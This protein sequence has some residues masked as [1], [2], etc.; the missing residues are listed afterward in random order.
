[1]NTPLDSFESEAS[2]LGR[3]KVDL[4]YS[5]FA[6]DRAREAAKSC[7]NRDAE[8]LAV[9]V[10]REAEDE[11]ARIDAR[12]AE[13]APLI[14]EIRHPESPLSTHQFSKGGAL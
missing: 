2:K 6:A 9:N 1:M 12:L 5:L 10:A 3:R 8:A 13:L 4:M 7:H 14:H 11:I